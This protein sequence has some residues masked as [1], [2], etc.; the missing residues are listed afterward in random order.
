MLTNNVIAGDFAQFS[1][2][3]HS[4]NTG[5]H[6]PAIASCHTD[7]FVQSHGTGI[8]QQ[9][10]NV[11]SDLKE[12]PLPIVGKQKFFSVSYLYIASSLTRRLSRSFHSLGRS[13]A[14]PLT[15]ALSTTNRKSGV[16]NIRTLQYAFREFQSIAT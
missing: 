5:H 14:A 1:K 3:Y 6:A 7:C 15:L 2:F 11:V 16:M 12:H 10:A 9:S 13:K 8:L 4:V